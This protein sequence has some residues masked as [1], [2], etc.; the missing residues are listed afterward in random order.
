M[1]FD[2]VLHDLG[3]VRRGQV[4]EVTLDRAA[5]VRLLDSSNFSPIRMDASTGTW[6]VTSPDRHTAE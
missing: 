3:Q 6:A 1:G 4:V 2:F 5:N